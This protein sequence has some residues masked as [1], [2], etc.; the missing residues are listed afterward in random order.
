MKVEFDKIKINTF[1]CL[2]ILVDGAQAV[3]C[4]EREN[5]QYVQSFIV[6]EA[7]HHIN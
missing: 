1:D 2:L 4:A 6:L 7:F 3:E 5:S